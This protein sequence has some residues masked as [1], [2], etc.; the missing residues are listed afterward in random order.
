MGTVAVTF[1]IMPESLDVNVEEIKN[2]ISKMRK[3]QDY[4]IETVA[5]G[6]KILRV[7]ILIPDQVGTEKIENEIK[8]VKGV[9][10]VEVESSTLI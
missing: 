1:K 2:E 3:I 9:S 8:N 6:L 5:F 7:L 4:N 10:E